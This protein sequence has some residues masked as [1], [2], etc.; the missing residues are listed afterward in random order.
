M[1]NIF[2]KS[3]ETVMQWFGS[4]TPYEVNYDV[5]TKAIYRNPSVAMAY[6]ILENAYCN[7]EFKVFKEEKKKIDGKEVSKFVP[8]NSVK[9]K[10]VNKSLNFPSR[11]TTRIEFMEYLLFYHMFGG[12]VLIER[13]NGYTSDELLLYAPTTYEIEYSNTATEMSKIT[14]AGVK[15]IIGEDLK[16]YFLTK[17]LDPSSSIA[18]VGAGSSKLEALAS[19]VDLINF[20]LKHNISL[21]KNRGNKGGFFKTTTE[22]RLT[23]RDREELESKLK[24]ATQGYQNAGKTAFLPSNVD[25]IDTSVNPKDIDWINGWELAH[26]MIAGIIGVPFSLVWDTASTY[27]NS[28][29][30]KTKLYKNTVLPIAKKHAEFLTTV[31]KDRLA[32]NEFVWVD[33]SQIEELR[34]ETLETLKALEGVSY[35]SINQKRDIASE[36]TGIELGKYAHENADKILTPMS[37]E[38]LDNIGETIEPVNEEE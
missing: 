11:L 15:E 6:E 33:L 19:I 13:K 30:D 17:S 31:F 7:I 27:N 28:R 25:F 21:L 32:E 10:Y 29:E 8:S 24:A 16:N 26:K 2:R 4:Y 12:R 20:M 18:G 14:I 37:I 5:Y 3:Y 34:H 36:L 38:I 9:A 1:F 22:T 23:E 35:I